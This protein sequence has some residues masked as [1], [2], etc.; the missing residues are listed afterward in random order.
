MSA[1]TYNL[2]VV[3]ESSLYEESNINIFF[4]ITKEE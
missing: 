3:I 1:T 4:Q 2:L